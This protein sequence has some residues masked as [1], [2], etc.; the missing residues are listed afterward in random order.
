MIMNNTSNNIEDVVSFNSDKTL[1]YCVMREDIIQMCYEIE[2]LE[3]V[4]KT[5]EAAQRYI[6]E[7]NSWARAKRTIET[8]ELE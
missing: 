3:K 8:M 5:R 6:D 4:F 7:A 2:V 1:V